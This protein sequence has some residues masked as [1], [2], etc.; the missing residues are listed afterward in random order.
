MKKLSDI[1]EEGALPLAD[2]WYVCKNNWKI[3]VSLACLCAFLSGMYALTRPVNYTAQG[4]FRI[5]KGSSTSTA[6]LLG[7]FDLPSD[8][9]EECM[10]LMT[11][12]RLLKPLIEQEGLQARV[13]SV[14][15]PR[16]S[17]GKWSNF[18]DN[19]TYYWNS[20]FNPYKVPRIPDLERGS[21]KCINT[22]YDKEAACFLTL[23]FDSEEKGF[24]VKK[25]K[26]VLG[27]GFF[28]LP[29]ETEDFS[30]TVVK[31]EDNFSKI[32]DKFSLVLRPWRDVADGLKVGLGVANSRKVQSMITVSYSSRDRHLAAEIVNGVMWSYQQYLSQEAYKTTTEQIGYLKDRQTETTDRLETLITNYAGTAGE[33]SQ[34]SNFMNVDS[35]IDF[36]AEA[37]TKLEEKDLVLSLE[38]SRLQNQEIENLIL[39]N[40]Y[41]D[42]GDSEVLEEILNRVHDLKQQRYAIE[43]ALSYDV[44]DVDKASDNFDQQIVEIEKVKK[45]IATIERSVEKLLQSHDLESLKN[46]LKGDF[47]VVPDLL[48]RFKNEQNSTVAE[49]FSTHKSYL[50]NYLNN[51]LF[52]NRLRLKVLEGRASYAQKAFVEFEGINLETANKL[53]MHFNTDLEQIQVRL[54]Q[55]AMV[56]EQMGSANFEISSLSVVLDDTISQKLITQA[57]ELSLET[58]DY[59]NRSSREIERL[60]QTL[61]LTRK[62]L[63]SHV[64]QTM[65]LLK[66]NENIV[67]DKIHAL[68]RTILDIIQQQI[69][70]SQ[71]QLQD[72]ISARKDNLLNEKRILTSEM[73]E[74]QSSISA[75]PQKWLREQKLQL[76]IDMETKMLANLASLVE[77][78]NITSNLDSIHS[79]PVDLAMAPTRPI[80]GRFMLYL[81]VGGF[82]GA[83]LGGAFFAMRM[84]H[85][86]LP[87]T[88]A[89][90]EMHGAHISGCL[91]KAYNEQVSFDQLNRQDL[92]PLRNLTSYFTSP[93]I[94]KCILLVMGEGPDYSG[95]FSHL[96]DKQGLKAVVL[97]LSLHKGQYEEQGLLQYLEGK[98]DFPEIHGNVINSGGHSIYLTEM[99]HS[100]R[101]KALLDILDSDY[102]IV[103]VAIDGRVNDVETKIL[104]KKAAG[105]A[106]TVQDE[107]LSDLEACLEEKLK[108]TFLFY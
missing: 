89:N 56:F 60:Q 4:I 20:T 48:G 107:K 36:L 39:Q 84:M 79:R 34:A 103:V 74:L 94:S 65:D 68:Q 102:D 17:S 54:Q 50:I 6:S 7:G 55:L 75:L 105:A 9:V 82:F 2:I 71:Q 101:L 47:D 21:L 30:F 11:S 40:R 85:T 58:R 5:Q 76:S 83:G 80:G 29:F 37:Q 81:V 61:A 8:D 10:R 92:I 86:G 28:D 12:Y 32:A 15:Y 38:I 91:T 97:N 59:S 62:F 87:A 70:L 51:Q 108:R 98:C 53:F 66:L 64:Q 31:S 27:E 90:L 25:G 106:I 69:V 99:L 93:E 88:K 46:C 22:H 16:R 73:D 19:I 18:R 42:V 49:Y 13:N 33:G 57:E 14:N 67:Q 52:L 45:H 63:T 23:E 35:Q 41:F 72:Y 3:I 104:M 100:T 1:Y 96:L 77:T 95:C 43:L 44:S 24:L 78:K 26:E